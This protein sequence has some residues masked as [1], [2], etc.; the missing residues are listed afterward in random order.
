LAADENDLGDIGGL[1]TSAVRS[2]AP[3]NYGA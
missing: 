3:I 2:I 1:Q